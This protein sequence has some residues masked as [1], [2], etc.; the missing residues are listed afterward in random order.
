MDL[1][2]HEK[3]IRDREV[4]EAKVATKEALA[5]TNASI[6]PSSNKGKGK[7]SMEEVPHTFVEQ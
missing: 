6:E 1:E 5:S 7:A 4:R 2:I 3:V